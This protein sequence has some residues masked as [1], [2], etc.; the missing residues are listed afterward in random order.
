MSRCPID[1]KTCHRETES[2]CP[3]RDANGDAECTLGNTSIPVAR[4][5]DFTEYELIPISDGGG[6][7]RMRLSM[8][9]R[10]YIRFLAERG[11][12]TP[13]DYSKVSSEV[14]RHL[15]DMIDMKLI[16]ETPIV[17][18]GLVRQRLTE[19]GRNVATTILKSVG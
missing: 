19:M 15:Q 9:H 12:E 18:S 5:K 7:V 17:G 6:S 8:T 2:H 14:K 11:G 16:D 4:G 1:H 3:T 13:F 10:A